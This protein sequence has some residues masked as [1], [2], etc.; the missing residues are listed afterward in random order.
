MDWNESVKWIVGLAG[1]K[2]GQLIGSRPGDLANLLFDFR[3]WLRLEPGEPAEKELRK[4]EQNPKELQPVLD[5]ITKLL[6]HIADQKKYE[7]RYEGGSL[8]LDAALLSSEGSRALSYRDSR[9]LDAVVQV[10]A[11]D[12]STES[13]SRIRRCAESSCRKIFYA[14]RNSKSYCTSRCANKTASRKYRSLN[15]AKRAERE[16]H[17]Y[18]TKMKQRTGPHVKIRKRPDI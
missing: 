9:L 3:R 7:Y 11:D 12:L 5:E 4:I 6:S 13:A 15:H 10:S 17:R 14:D 18:E 2:V 8:T 16:R 1:K